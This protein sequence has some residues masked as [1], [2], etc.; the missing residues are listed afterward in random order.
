[1]LRIHYALEEKKIGGG[2]PH[3]LV[4][5]CHPDVA[6]ILE[7]QDEQWYLKAPCCGR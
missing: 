4:I 7:T 6:D 2:I 1:M 3:P 5:E